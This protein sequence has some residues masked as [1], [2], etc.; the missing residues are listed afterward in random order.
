MKRVVQILFVSIIVLFVGSLLIG[1]GGLFSLVN[2]PEERVEKPSILALELSGIITTGQDFLDQLRKYRKDDRVKA[3]LIKIN[4]PGGV[5]GPSQ[6]M[7]DEIKRTREEFKK[8]VIAFCSAVMA[9]GGYYAAAGADQI[10]TTPGCMMGSIGVIMQFANLEK[11]YDWAKIQRY[12]LTTGKFKDA[13]A[14]YKPMTEEQRALFQEMLDDV[15]TQFKGAII[16]GRKMKPE[17][18]NQYADGRI[19]TGA[20]GVKLGF[21][22]K[23][24]SWDDARKALGE[25]VGLGP[26]PKVFKPKKRRGFSALFEEEMTEEARLRQFTQELFKTELSGRPLFIFPGAMGF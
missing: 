25:M 6:E 16:D 26:D 1:I 24:G 14:D 19:F 11:L 9:S 13:G 2:P 23:V 22:D 10:Y 4:S 5:V 18:L 3:V 12:A 17:F 20:Q 8:P 15:L 7:F 21:A